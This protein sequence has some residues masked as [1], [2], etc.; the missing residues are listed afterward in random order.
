MLRKNMLKRKLQAGETVFGLFSSTPSPVAVEMIGCAGFDFVI[1]DTEHV[2]INP[3][4]LENMIRAAEAVHLTVLV[5]VPDCSSGPILRALDAGAQGIVAPHVKTIEEAEAIVQASRYHP[6]GNR[7]LNG[8]RPAAFG[9]LDLQAYIRD[10]NEE[11]MAVPLIED[12]EGVERID[13]ILSVPGIDMVLEGAADLSQSYG[14]PWQTRAP[15]V[16]DALRRVQE[17]AKNRGVPYCA[18]PRADEDLA[19]WRGRGVRAFVLG[20]ERGIAFRA[21]CAHRSKF[22]NLAESVA[23]QAHSAEGRESG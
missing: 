8:G 15:V 12:R 10:A 13:D 2:S 11:I 1:V 23:P 20:D 7:S 22:E 16:K 14:V 3:E 17:S 21:L 19:D 6:Q 18:I 4:T 9:K 5:R